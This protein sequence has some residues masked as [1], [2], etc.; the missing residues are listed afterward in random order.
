MFLSISFHSCMHPFLKN[1]SG[2]VYIVILNSMCMLYT[3][4]IIS[5]TSL[6]IS[7]LRGAIAPYKQGKI[8]LFRML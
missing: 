7:V 5:H 8:G 1:T 4:A 2:Q 6:T 3:F